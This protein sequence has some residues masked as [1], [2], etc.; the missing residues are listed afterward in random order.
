MNN[1]ELKEKIKDL[2]KKYKD[3][4][5]DELLDYLNFILKDKYS[6][7]SH[8]LRLYN[9][10][11][12]TKKLYS[13]FITEYN[14]NDLSQDVLFVTSN[15]KYKESGIYDVNSNKKV[16]IILN[17]NTKDLFDLVRYSIILDQFNKGNDEIVSYIKAM[18]VEKKLLDYLIKIGYSEV[19]C[20]KIKEYNLMEV[21]YISNILNCTIDEVKFYNQVLEVSGNIVHETEKN[22]KKHI[23]INEL[24]KY[25]LINSKKYIYGII[26]STYLHQNLNDDEISKLLNTSM[27][28]NDFIDGYIKNV[29]KEKIFDYYEKE[30][31]C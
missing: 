22:I 12:K 26:Y 1:C 16:V 28:F 4:K 20:E 6:T 3:L 10:L 17:N 8:S 29:D 14:L 24:N 19:E 11:D 15:H 13:S 5:Q 27:K 2:S 9:N 18:L 7:K 23:D 30:Y 31:R 25:D 21:L